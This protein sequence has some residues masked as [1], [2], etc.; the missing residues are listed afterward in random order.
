MAQERSLLYTPSGRAGE[1]AN[2][3]YAANLYRGCTHGCQYCYVPAST[4]MSR[5]DFHSG[6]VPVKDMIKRLTADMKRVGKLDEPIFLCFTCD[7]YCIDAPREMT[8]AAIE[9]IM[10]AGNAVNI[11]TKGGDLAIADF[12]LLRKNPKNKIGATLTFSN[13]A[14]SKE[15]EP[16]AASPLHRVYM[17]AM[18]KDKGIQTWASIEPVIFPSQSL[19]IMEE[20]LP[21]VDEFKI[22]I[23]NHDYRAIN[24]ERVR[25]YRAR[26]MMAHV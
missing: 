9:I 1:Y 26:K 16:L 21:H 15:W 22:G 10:E 12:D 18:A 14:L 8:R 19:Q 5:E 23:W 11:L 7:P 24:R 20:A 6:V 25:K 13:E 4:R 17:L 2:H 3:G